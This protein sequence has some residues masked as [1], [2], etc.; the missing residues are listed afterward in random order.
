MNQIAR[1]IIK[2]VQEE[3]SGFQ[4]IVSYEDIE[5]EFGMEAISEVI[6]NMI[7]DEMGFFEE[8][9]DVELDDYGFDVVLCT[10]YAPNYEGDD[11]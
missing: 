3:S 7:A 11:E 1:F 9:A 10:D 5:K 8:V 4:C 2:K 6:A